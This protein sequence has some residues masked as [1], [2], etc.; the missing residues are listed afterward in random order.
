MANLGYKGT[1]G[2]PV[3]WL[4][5]GSLIS[6]R[7][8]L[9]AAHCVHGRKDLFIVK[10]GEHIL[11]DD[12]DGANPIDVKIEKIIPHPNYNPSG[13]E[14]DIAILKLEKS[15]KFNSKF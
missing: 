3:R 6:D 9:T 8:I 15:V 13:L 1:N 7:H 14:N 5:G 10:L 2:K 12:N 11:N 4:C